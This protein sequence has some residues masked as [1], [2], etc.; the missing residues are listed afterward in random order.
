MH[1]WTSECVLSF[2]ECSDKLFKT[3]ELHEECTDKPTSE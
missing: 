2:E 1:N 3:I